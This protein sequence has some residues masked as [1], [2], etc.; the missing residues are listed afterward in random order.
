MTFSVSN[1]PIPANHT[2]DLIRVTYHYG[3]RI[4]QEV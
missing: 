2:S 1:T 4:Y 3:N